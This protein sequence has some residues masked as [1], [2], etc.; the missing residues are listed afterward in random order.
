MIRSMIDND[1]WNEELEL[2]RSQD[3][4]E[5]IWQAMQDNLEKYA[6]GYVKSLSTL[7][8]KSFRG[9]VVELN[10]K[11]IISD[12]QKLHDKYHDIFALDLFEEEY[13]EDPEGFKST[14]LRKE[15]DAIRVTLNSR[16]EVLVEW[17][18]SFNRSKAKE[19]YDTFYN[20]MSFADDYNEAMT[21]EKLS[22]LDS[23]D[24]LG[25]AQMGEDACY[26][27]GVLGFGLVSN[28]LNHMYP[29]VFPGN[30]KLGIYSMHFL[31]GKISKSI[32]P[33]ESSE[34]IMV[35]DDVYSKTGIIEAEHNYYFPYSVYA[36]YALR[37]YRLLDA[38]LKEKVNH[39][40]PS[41]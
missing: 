37:I 27:S 31:S 21:E 11:N 23:I 10:F 8:D 6:D 39:S 7:F 40:F 30:Y 1:I 36:L 2:M 35:K 41:E 19:L 22:G 18:K 32:M 24:G 26:K 14:T 20:M 28:I 12:N 9:D 25:F 4:L 5:E 3:H 13:S 15:C 38:K 16:S 17:Q 33:S 34:F 29:R